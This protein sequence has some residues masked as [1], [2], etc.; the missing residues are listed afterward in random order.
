MRPFQQFRP[1][2][3]LVTAGALT[4]VLAVAGCGGGGAAT[5]AATAPVAGPAVATRSGPAGD[6]LTDSSGR[7]LYLFAADTGSASTCTGACAQEWPPYTADRKPAVAGAATADRVGTSARPGGTRQVTYAGHPLY[8]FAG[9]TSAG[10]TGGQGLNDFGAR[11]SMVHPDG[12][13][14]TGAA[15][16]SSDDSGYSSGY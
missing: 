15:A 5:A 10:L 4:A 9:D 2:A 12:S 1:R 11:W 6:Y 3:L 14:V 8:Y 16:N 7:T 13:A